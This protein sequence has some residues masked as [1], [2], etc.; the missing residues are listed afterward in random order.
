MV[1]DPD[2][3]I[4]FIDKQETRLCEMPSKSNF[5][6]FQVETTLNYTTIWQKDLLYLYLCYFYNPYIQKVHT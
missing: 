6:K 4:L 2:I 3:L 1:F 5:Y